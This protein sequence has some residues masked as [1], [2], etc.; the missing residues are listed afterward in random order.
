MGFQCFISLLGDA[1][2]EKLKST[3][4][5]LFPTG[6][7]TGVTRDH[8]PQSHSQPPLQMAPSI[9]PLNRPPAGGSRFQHD[10]GILPPARVQ[11]AEQ[12]PQYG[13]S[14][15]GGP[16]QRTNP[17]P[18]DY[19]D[20]SRGPPPP[21]QPNYDDSRYRRND[22][23][24]DSRGAPPPAPPSNG[25]QSSAAQ[26]SRSHDDYT[27]QPSHTDRAYQPENNVVYGSTGRN[28][29]GRTYAAKDDYSAQGNYY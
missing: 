28:N 16:S 6:G 14:Q 11:Y 12:N 24:Y 13:G 19:Y 5:Q 21:Q 17:Q 22:T 23:Q 4:S 7:V 8:Q 25:Y 18:N 10:I 9:D 2:T 15:I 1:S 26:A 27:R 20:R 29:G 3:I